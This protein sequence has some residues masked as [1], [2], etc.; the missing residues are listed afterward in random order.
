VVMD[1]NGVLDDPSLGTI[2]QQMPFHPIVQAAASVY[3]TERLPDPT[4]TNGTRQFAK[5]AINYLRN[6]MGVGGEGLTG[7]PLANLTYKIQQLARSIAP[8]LGPIE[9]VSLSAPSPG[10]K[11]TQMVKYY[12]AE[13]MRNTPDP[14]TGGT[15]F[16]NPDGSITDYASQ[17]MANIDAGL[18]SGSV[19][20]EA[21]DQFS[22]DTFTGRVAMSALPIQSL[23]PSVVGEA[24]LENRSGYTAAN[25]PLELDTT[26]SPESMAFIDPSR[27]ETTIEKGGSLAVG[28]GDAGSPVS[29]QLVAALDQYSNLGDE[30]IQ[31]VYTHYNSFVYGN[32]DELRQKYGGEGLVI[33]GEQ[34]AWEIWG[35]LP[36]DAR[37]TYMDSWLKTKGFYESVSAYR[38]ERDAFEAAHPEVEEFKR[39]QSTVGEK[40]GE[41]MLA[42]LLSGQYPA[43]EA[44]WKTQDV[45]PAKIQQMLMTPSAYLAS[46]GHEPSLWDINDISTKPTVDASKA[47]PLDTIAPKDT[48]NTGF[49]SDRPFEALTAEEKVVRIN[50]KLAVY[51]A[52]M[53]LFNQEIAPYTGGKPYTALGPQGIAIL[54]AIMQKQGIT[55]P[56]MPSV[57]KDYVDWISS[58]PASTDTSISVYVASLAD[59]A[60]AA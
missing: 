39:W 32:G 9:A 54:D 37:R 56:S 6:E 53:D 25:Q 3:L 50:E 12:A 29:G 43:F 49:S 28:L 16:Q 57:V 5:A 4:G 23:Y 13:I 15:L 48:S 47:S 22:T 45:K 44:W 21:L 31:D 41:A 11:D 38:A 34:F 51:S 46:I 27:P 59:E 52:E 35:A 26:T 55:M 1:A 7:D 60:I 30:Q 58:Q 17:V 19:E 24:R 20:A 14:E 18:Y 36:D 2:L 40:G 33:N 8:D 10:Q 42:Q